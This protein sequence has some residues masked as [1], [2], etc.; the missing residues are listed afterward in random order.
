MVNSPKFSFGYG[1]SYTQ[2]NYGKLKLSKTTLSATDKLEAAVV[3]TNA[4]NYDGE[5]VVQ[6]YLRDMVGSVV[7]PV[8][9]LKGFQK[10][11]LK[12]GESREVKFILSV[13]DLK[14]YNDALK[15][16]WEPGE[17]SIMIGPN[18]NTVQALPVQWNR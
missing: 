16:D 15:Y 8:K 11:L 5:E 6:L 18:A 9:E 1:L 12:K 3:V 4:G 14:F 7:R 2:F 17:F 13:N 10:I